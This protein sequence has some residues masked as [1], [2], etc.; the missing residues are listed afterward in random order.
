MVVTLGAVMSATAQAAEPF[1]FKPQSRLAKL[2][3][4]FDESG[5]RMTRHGNIAAGL[6]VFMSPPPE[7]RKS[8]LDSGGLQRGMRN[9]S[10]VFLSIRLPW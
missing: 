3:A 7:V 10:D 1:Q 4:N 6:H 9:K 2:T 8:Y 5:Y